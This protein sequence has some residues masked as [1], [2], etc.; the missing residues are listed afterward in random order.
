MLTC[1][2]CFTTLFYTNDRFLPPFSRYIFLKFDECNQIFTKKKL[3]FFGLLKPWSSVVMDFVKNFFFHNLLKAMLNFFHNTYA[4][5]GL[6]TLESLLRGIPAK[7]FFNSKFVSQLSNVF[8]SLIFNIIPNSVS[9]PNFFLNQ[10]FTF[11]PKKIYCNKS[12]KISRRKKKDFYFKVGSLTVTKE[13]EILC[14]DTAHSNRTHICIYITHICIIYI[15]NII[16]QHFLLFTRSFP[17]PGILL[18]QDKST[19]LEGESKKWDIF[20]RSPWGIVRLSNYHDS[21]F[22]KYI[23]YYYNILHSKD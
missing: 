6:A 8:T 18:E 7:F 21:K 17:R 15:Y 3:R 10:I 22:F 14:I 16:S 12:P 11:H 2:N 4:P 19:I 23:P 1:F 20:C 9:V 5:P 13:Q